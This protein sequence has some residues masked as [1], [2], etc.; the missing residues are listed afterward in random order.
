VGFQEYRNGEALSA[1]YYKS[2][3]NDTDKIKE[4]RDNEIAAPL[5]GEKPL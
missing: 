1:G 5:S 4:R 2:G 3:A